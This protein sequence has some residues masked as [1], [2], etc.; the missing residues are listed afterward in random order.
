MLLLLPHCAKNCELNFKICNCH[1]EI[2]QTVELILKFL[3]QNLFQ[4]KNKVNFCTHI[5]N[6]QPTVCLVFLSAL[7][8]GIFPIQFFPSEFIEY[9]HE[10]T[11]HCKKVCFSPIRTYCYT[12]E[13]NGGENVNPG[14]QDGGSQYKV[15]GSGGLREASR[16]DLVLGLPSLREGKKEGHERVCLPAHCRRGRSGP[17]ARQ[18]SMLAQQPSGLGE[19]SRASQLPTC[20]LA[21]CLSLHFPEVE[22]K[23]ME[24]G[25][26]TAQGGRADSPTSPFIS[27]EPTMVVAGGPRKQGTNE[28]SMRRKCKNPSAI[29]F[30]SAEFHNAGT[31]SFTDKGEK[32]CSK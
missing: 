17:L 21:R 20:P 22:D 30:S 5:L 14:H 28:S 9:Y 19:Q 2:K 7:V 25:T 1:L 32:C 15:L 8:Q 27:P 23:K 16:A 26:P 4:L 12:K 18:L 6:I 29:L 10:K 3:V 11:Q 13:N 24:V 31:I